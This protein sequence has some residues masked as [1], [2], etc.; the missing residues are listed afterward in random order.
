MVSSPLQ[1]K[2][3]Y[4]PAPL[5]TLPIDPPMFHKGKVKLS[6]QALMTPIKQKINRFEE[7]IPKEIP[8][9]VPI[10]KTP[11]PMDIED[12]PPVQSSWNIMKEPI[13]VSAEPFIR[14]ASVLS[15]ISDFVFGW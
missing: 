7:W 14:P 6:E 3:L 11:T 10:S 9:V 2:E 12:E 8:D 15:R 4:E 1:S 13:A 5:P